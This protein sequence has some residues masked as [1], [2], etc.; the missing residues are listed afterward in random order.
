MEKDS[1]ENY[2]KHTIN[3]I[4]NN[5]ISAKEETPNLSSE[6]KMGIL[7]AYSEVLSILKNQAPVYNLKEEDIGLSDIEPEK[8]LL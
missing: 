7:M 3:L 2:M 5:A 4:K 8:D 1:L 6:Y